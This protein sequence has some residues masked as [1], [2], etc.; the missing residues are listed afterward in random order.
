MARFCPNKLWARSSS[1]GHFV[2]EGLSEPVGVKLA[3]M[4]TV[5]PVAQDPV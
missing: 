5:R 2:S 1:T 3:E 4:S